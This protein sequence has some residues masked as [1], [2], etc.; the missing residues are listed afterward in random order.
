MTPDRIDEL[1]D[2]RDAAAA[3]AETAHRELV[4]AVVGR[5]NRDPD[6]N[7]TANAKRARISRQTLY[8]EL[9]KRQEAAD[10]LSSNGDTPAEAPADE[11]R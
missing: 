2:R 10:T 11:D 4:D 7:H 3:E 5:G 1:A 6:V 8:N 9:G